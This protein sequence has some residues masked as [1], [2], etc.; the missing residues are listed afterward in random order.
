MEQSVLDRMGSMTNTSKDSYKK[1][2]AIYNAPKIS[3]G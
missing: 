3:V 2:C 1:V